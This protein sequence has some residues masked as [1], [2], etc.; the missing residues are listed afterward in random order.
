MII[1]Q[2]ADFL[3]F[4]VALS[5]KLQQNERIHGLFLRIEF[6]KTVYM[7]AIFSRMYMNLKN[8]SSVS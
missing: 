3:S 1:R 2:V 5:E 6:H 4:P 7:C 8:N